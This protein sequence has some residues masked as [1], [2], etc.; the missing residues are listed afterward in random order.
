[1]ILNRMHFD[2]NEAFKF[3]PTKSGTYMLRSWG[4]WDGA[5]LDVTE[6]ESGLSVASNAA[7]ARDEVT[8]E[9]GIEI[10]VT[11]SSAGAGT[12]LDFSISLIQWTDDADRRADK[13]GR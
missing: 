12:V 6:V 2:A 10:A 8:L 1:M 11:C 4:T 3:T 13:E 9:R 7:D 5:D